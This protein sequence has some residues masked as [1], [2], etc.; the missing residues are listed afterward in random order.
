MCG[1]VGII[2]KD[3][4]E[5]AESDLKTAMQAIRHRGPDGEGISIVRNVGLANVRL[6]ILDLDKRSDMPMKFDHLIMT[7]NGEV[8]NYKEIREELESKGYTFSTTGDTEVVIKSYHYWGSEC[9]SKFNG[10]WS[11]AIHDTL[12]RIVFCA[13][14][15]FGIKPFYYTTFDNKF[16][17]ASEIKAITKINGWKAT[18]NMETA[19][20][21]L[22]YGMQDYDH[23]TFFQDVNQL[24]PSH[25]LTY[26]VEENKIQI[27]KYYDIEKKTLSYTED[28]AKQKFYELFSSSITLR[29]RSDVKVGSCLSGGLDSSSIVCLS[30]DTLLTD[31]FETVSA[32]YPNTEIDESKFIKDIITDKGIINFSFSPDLNDLFEKIPALIYSQD[33][34]FSS[35]SIFA[36]NEV[37]RKA[38]EVGLKVMLDGQGGDEILAGYDVFYY[39]LLKRKMKNNPLSALLE[40]INFLKSYNNSFADA[41][42]KY[43]NARKK[44][45]HQ[46]PDWL[47]VPIDSTRSPQ[48][49]N[50][51]D[52][53]STS[54]SL[55]FNMGIQALLHYEDRNSMAHSIESRLP[56]LDYRLVE[57][58]LQLPDQLKINKGIRKYILRESM[59]PHLPDAIYSRLDKLGFETPQE[60]WMKLNK[61][62]I[63]EQTRE[64]SAEIPWIDMNK[65]SADTNTLWRLFLYSNWWKIFKVS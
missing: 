44:N 19:A 5:A 16:C 3:K 51:T 40:M 21:Y 31:Q 55:L 2:H 33:G 25:H 18:A 8:Y 30:S 27:D 32:V 45:A 34:P 49:S 12:S 15:R 62:K 24:P 43:K 23:Q 11:F 22:L 46:L 1:I 65:F 60:E 36:Q 61:E 53:F 38:N 63:Y 64:L 35:A 47:H 56:F 37:F 29:F 6:A 7:Y 14:D 50:K 20:Y 39:S 41:I 10:M 48:S 54:K 59:K 26:S 58:C 17:F 9:V 42:K 52:V 13:R 57:F 4:K 28:E